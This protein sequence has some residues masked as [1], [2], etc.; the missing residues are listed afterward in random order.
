MFDFLLPFVTGF[1]FAKMLTPTR[2]RFDRI[3]GW[4]ETCLG[5]RPVVSAEKIQSEK[6]YLLCH[7]VDGETAERLVRL[8]D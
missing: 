5:W 2:V 4:N 7:E 6:K 3:L 8:E 1:F